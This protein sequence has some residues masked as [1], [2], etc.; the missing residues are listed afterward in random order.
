MSFIYKENAQKKAPTNG[1]RLTLPLGFLGWWTLVLFRL[2]ESCVCV[3]VCWTR[4]AQSCCQ[5]FWL[6]FSWFSS[7]FWERRCCNACTSRWQ[8]NK[9]KTKPTSTKKDQRK[10]HKSLGRLT[11]THAVRTRDELILVEPQFLA[12]ICASSYQVQRFS[13]LCSV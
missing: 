8:Q 5:T 4:N 12:D 1:D 7:K 10:T 3:S 13:F 9:S 11:C 2:S 6:V